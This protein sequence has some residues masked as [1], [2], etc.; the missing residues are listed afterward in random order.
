MT[1]R[2]KS[3][4]LPAVVL[5]G[6]V[7]VGKSSLFNRLAE[8]PSALVS[9]VPG[10]TRDR[11]ESTIEWR[12][13]SFRLVDTGGVEDPA[14]PER[15]TKPDAFQGLVGAQTERAITD[16]DLILLVVDARDGVLPQDRQW[17]KRL[18]GNATV[19]LVV[20]KVDGSRLAQSSPEFLSLG[21]GEP[22]LV[23]ATTGRGTGD[24]LDIIVDAVKKSPSATTS[25]KGELDLEGAL[26]SDKSK[27]V[28]KIAIL[29]QPNVGKSTL[30]NAI[31][32]DQ[33][34]ITSPIA[35]TTREPIDIPFTYKEHPLILID[36][37]GVRRRAH[38]KP[39]LEQAGVRASLS[40]AERAD[41]VLLV[42]DSMLGP[43][44]QDQHL[45]RFIVDHGKGLVLIANKWDLVP[46][47]TAKSTSEIERAWRRLMPGLNWVPL[48][49]VSA[50]TRLR[51][52]NVLDT[53][54]GAQRAAEVTL[55]QEMLDKFL[56]LVIRQHRPM[57]GS[58]VRHPKI[59]SLKQISVTPPRFEIVVIGELHTAYVKFLENRLREHFGFAGTPISINLETKKKR[60]EKIYKRKS[61]NM[62][63]R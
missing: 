37:A 3:S 20:N 54:I 19:K 14:S 5:I 36:T 22:L 4:N 17:A 16:S 56:Q 32:N 33:R 6:R 26:A 34:V 44:R 58:G 43:S 2:A 12:G 29:G 9:P 40:T 23:S 63:P 49:F 18:R 24:L 7:N 15:A 27:Q 62:L 61:V 30:L 21:F 1:K 52:D 55:T 59:L 48:L 11:R 28:L 41:V 46:S 45:A 42:L 60:V 53:A 35:H 8:R 47:K 31:V 39:G 10:T 51:V 38:I 57:R 50:T 13:V 25:S